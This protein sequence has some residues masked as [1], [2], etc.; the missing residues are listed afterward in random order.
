[1]TVQSVQSEPFYLV[2]PGS[3]RKRE[4]VPYQCR[5]IHQSEDAA[6]PGCVL[7]WEVDG[8][9]DTYQVALERTEDGMLRWHCTCADHV[10]RKHVCK[11]IRGLRSASNG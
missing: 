11:H 10:Y 1:M 3:D 8:G 7:A 2:M 9:R 6:E 4:P 5:L